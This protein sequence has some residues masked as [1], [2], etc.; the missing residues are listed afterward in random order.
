MT[1]RPKHWRNDLIRP[2]TRET[3]NKILEM[4]D[5]GLLNPRDVLLMAL[6]WMSE[7]DVKAMAKAN[8]LD[9]EQE[10]EFA[11]LEVCK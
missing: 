5:E 4:V 9:L 11:D 3:T 7:D 6:K 8:E 2:D 10:E 1:T